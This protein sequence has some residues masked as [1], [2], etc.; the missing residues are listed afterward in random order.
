MLLRH[1]YRRD[2]T[3]IIEAGR[4]SGVAPA[5]Y[6][7]RIMKQSAKEKSAASGVSG[8]AATAPLLII[9]PFLH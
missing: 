7:H 5:R 6:A 2:V 4:R 1:C 9:I 8:M 3:D